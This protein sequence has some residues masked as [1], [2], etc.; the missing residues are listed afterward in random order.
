MYR[1]KLFSRGH[2]D[3]WRCLSIDPSALSEI[4]A[5]LFLSADEKWL[6]NEFINNNWQNALFDHVS[7]LT[8]L[9]LIIFERE[10]RK[11]HHHI[12]LIQLMI[13][14]NSNPIQKSGNP[15]IVTLLFRKI[16]RIVSPPNHIDFF[17]LAPICWDKI[18]QIIISISWHINILIL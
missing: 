18:K 3:E 1:G 7:R 16:P 15:F 4:F 12:T 2:I 6:M 10:R 9:E 14:G 8:I 11:T 13:D 17:S 5:D